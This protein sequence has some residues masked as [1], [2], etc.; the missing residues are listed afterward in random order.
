MSAVIGKQKL[1]DENNIAQYLQNCKC[2]RN[3]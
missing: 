3:G 2:Y 1:L